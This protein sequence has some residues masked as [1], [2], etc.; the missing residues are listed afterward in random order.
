MGSS[1][2]TARPAQ[3]GCYVGVQLQ[4]E[5]CSFRCIVPMSALLTQPRVHSQLHLMWSRCQQGDAM[6]QPPPQAAIFR[7]SNQLPS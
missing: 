6:S 3:Q 7:P 1:V 4:V 2:G 5:V